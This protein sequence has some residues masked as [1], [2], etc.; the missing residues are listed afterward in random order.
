[1]TMRTITISSLNNSM[2]QVVRHKLLL[3]SL[4][5]QCADKTCG[6]NLSSCFACAAKMIV[7]ELN[8]HAQ[9]AAPNSRQF[10]IGHVIDPVVRHELKDDNA[11][12]LEESL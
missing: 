2:C 10:S 12:P 11:A 1:M 8:Q 4:K 9:V 3:N 6:C 5:K 7:G